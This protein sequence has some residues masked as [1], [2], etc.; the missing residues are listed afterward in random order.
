MVRETSLDG[1]ARPDGRNREPLEVAPGAVTFEERYRRHGHKPGILLLGNRLA[2]AKSLERALFD[3]GFHVVVLDAFGLPLLTLKNF[4]NSMYSAGLLVLCA[5]AW[6]R[7]QN[8]AELSSLAVF[9]PEDVV[10]LS[11]ADY[12]TDDD[13]ILQR[14]LS[15]AEKLRVSR[16]QASR[17]GTLK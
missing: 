11:A 4:L 3:S 16:F 17:K 9:R 1:A 6:P 7:P 12:G 5:N 14:A 15:F 2:L 10:E 8:L 13:Q